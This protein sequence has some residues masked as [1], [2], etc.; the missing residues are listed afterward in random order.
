MPSPSL[1]AALTVV[2]LAACALAW[3]AAPRAGLYAA[4]GGAGEL[5]ID[6][7]RSGLRFSIESLGANGHTCSLEG[8][9]RGGVGTVDSDDDTCRVALQPA[10]D[11]YEVEAL[12]PE[13]CRLWCGMR[14]GFEATYRPL[15]PACGA[16]RYD[17]RRAAFLAL[18]KARR[19]R[20]ALAEAT[21]PRDECGWS[22]WFID[23]D[24]LANDIAIT[25]YHLKRPA[26]C[27]ATLKSTIG[28]DFRRVEDASE[29]LAPADAIGYAPVA[30]AT[31]TN[32]RLCE[33]ALTR[34]R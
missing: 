5:R 26:D 4:E 19:Y 15:P 3:A 6:A 23:A 14:A 11:G 33:K 27:L 34:P 13:T 32:R 12:T 31:I 29:E 17:A 1:R 21:S 10:G 30:R 25:Q 24:A 7:A 8:E 22:R 20:E 28:W 9:V 2:A 18:Y 16:T